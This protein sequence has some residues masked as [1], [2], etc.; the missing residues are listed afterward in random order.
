MA[1]GIPIRVSAPSHKFTF[2]KKAL[3]KTM[4]AAGAEVAKAARAQLRSSTGSGR[5][6]YGSGGSSAYRGGYKS[7]RYQAS[8]PGQA[9]VRVTGTLARSI[10]VR[11][12]KSGE[13]VAIRSTAFYALF[14]EAGA[15]GGGR[16]A[17]R[18][19]RMIRKQQVT[20][21]RVLE[22]RQFLTVALDERRDGLRKR[23]E[24]SVRQDIGFAKVKS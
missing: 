18:G 19:K 3:R 22:P 20:T 8:A 17:T 9:P 7:G 14:L 24:A 1:D 5:V 2:D 11:P 12:F 6:Y 16:K 21:G 23:I 13:G 4:R 10:K 15:T